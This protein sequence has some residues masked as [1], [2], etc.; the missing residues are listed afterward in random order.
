MDSGTLL[1]LQLVAAGV[2]AYFGAY[3]AKRGQN[4]AILAD[5]NKLLTQV[6]AVTTTTKQIEARISIDVWSRQQRWE[7]QKAALL[8]T[9][10][11]LA[12]AEAAVWALVSTL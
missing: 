11:E 7:V 8:D 4:K 2:A 5:L 9:L 1:V 12:S 3:W 6:S 10:R